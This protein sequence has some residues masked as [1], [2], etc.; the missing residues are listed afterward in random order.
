M[1]LKLPFSHTFF[2]SDQSKLRFPAKTV[3]HFFLMFQL[4]KSL[5]WERNIAFLIPKGHCTKE[6]GWFSHRTCS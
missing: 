4:I 5:S 2:V 1:A 3:D 6:G